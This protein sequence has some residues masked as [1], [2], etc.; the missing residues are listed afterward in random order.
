MRYAI[1]LYDPDKVV[2]IEGDVMVSGLLPVSSRQ[3]MIGQLRDGEIASLLIRRHYDLDGT[4]SSIVEEND[5]A[6]VRLAQE[7]GLW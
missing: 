1:C 3:A 6:S 2:G 7:L 4:N 5:L